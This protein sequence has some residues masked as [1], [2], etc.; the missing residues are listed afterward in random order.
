MNPLV[1][2]IIPYYN[3]S[4]T[5]E[6]TVN[7]I[8]DQTYKN[9]EIWIINDGSDETSTKKLDLF[10]ENNKINIIHQ[11]NSGPSIARNNAIKKTNAEYIIPVDADDEICKNTVTNNIKHLIEN[12]S[13]GVVYGNLKYFGVK[14]Y[15]LNQT[16]KFELKKQFLM[17]QIAICCIIKKSV[18]ET[19]GYY[20]EFL[21]KPGLEDWEFWIR[22]FNNGW[23]FKKV[24]EV[25]FKI[26]LSEKSRT[27]QKSRFVFFR[28]SAAA[29]RLEPPRPQPRRGRGHSRGRS[30]EAA[31]AAAKPPPQPRKKN[32]K[33]RKTAE[34]VDVFTDPP[35]V[36][37]PPSL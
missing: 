4:D 8:I 28:Q 32:E 12:Q 26:R 37:D 18:F 6:C 27:L 11:E 9:Y 14:E 30:R 20:D 5:I 33:K 13:I 7:S 21:S 24:E 25:F 17:N 16:K 15:I 35:L 2:F 31:A 22:V 1:S 3:S 34:V 36:R 23:E 10:K 19:A 29:A